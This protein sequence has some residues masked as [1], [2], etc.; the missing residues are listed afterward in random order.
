MGYDAFSM[1]LLDISLVS[2]H[3]QNHLATKVWCQLRPAIYNGKHI[4]KHQS[5]TLFLASLHKQTVL[6]HPNFDIFS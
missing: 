1:F 2:E 6:F 5:R 3:L 4:K